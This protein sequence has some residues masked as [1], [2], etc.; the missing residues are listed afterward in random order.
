MTLLRGHIFVTDD[1]FDALL[2]EEAIT[3]CLMYRRDHGNRV[4]PER[5]FVLQSELHAVAATEAR[6]AAKPRATP[7]AAQGEVSATMDV[8]TASRILKRS[9]AMVRRY[10]ADGTLTAVKRRQA[11]LIDARSVHALAAEQESQSA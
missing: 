11:Y 2:L 7:A 4:R 9:T 10:C 8:V 6:H 1:A 5:L 3:E